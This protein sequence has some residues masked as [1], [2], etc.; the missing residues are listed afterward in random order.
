MAVPEAG[1]PPPPLPG[2][3]A[4]GASPP[5]LSPLSTAAAPGG[6]PASPPNVD[7]SPSPRA[8]RSPKATRPGEGTGGEVPPDPA[9]LQI[10]RNLFSSVAEEMGVALIRSSY[11]PNIKERRDLSCALFD[12]QG[13]LVAQ[14][15]HIPVHLGAMAFSVAAAIERFRLAPGDVVVLNDPFLG[16]THLPDITVVSPVFAPDGPTDTPAAFVASRAH[17]ADVGG[18]VPGSMPQSTEIYQEGIII[19]PVKIIDR[20]QLNEAVLEII[21]R[22]CRTPEE[23]QG[24]LA[25][26]LAAHR[27]GET[28]LHE[29]M[30]KYGVAEVRRQM[31]A[32]IDYAERL[33]R[34][35]IAAIPNGR[36]E[37]IDYLDDDG[38]TDQPI[39]IQVAVTVRGDELEVD[40][41]GSDAQRRGCINAPLA[42]TSSATLYVVRCLSDERVPANQGCLN[43]VRLVA[44]LGS[45]V[46][47]TPPVGVCGGNTETSQRIT[48]VLLGALAPVLPARIPAAGQGTA[49]NLTYGGYD[50]FRERYYAYYE[51]VGGGMGASAQRAGMSGAHVHM[52]NTQNTPAEALEFAFPVRIREYALRPGSGGAGRHRGGDGLR[53]AVEFLA[54]ATVT[55]LTERRRFPPYGLEGGAPGAVGRNWLLRPDAEPRLLPGKGT[56]DVAAGDAVLVETPGGGGWGRPDG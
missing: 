18:M 46:N 41:T 56:V 32:L 30:N 16:G 28:R 53:R 11:S 3:H 5:L 31:A 47:A 14:A 9:T 19:P 37:F 35:T 45:V 42:V 21:C 49:N 54:P 27:V 36:Y 48:D 15:A 2:D 50:P 8:E 40:F 43:P 24:D 6:A 13:R 29:L 52:T 12:A 10:F 44:P 23:R 1:R 7:R 51:T 55:L 26:Q 34:A 25:A 4:D 38:V 17:H 22:N 39:R 33:T 20:G